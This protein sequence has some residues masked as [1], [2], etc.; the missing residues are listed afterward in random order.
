MDDVRS[1]LLTKDAERFDFLPEPE[2][3]ANTEAAPSALPDFDLDDEED[4][5][6]DEDAPPPGAAGGPGDGG[7]THLPDFDDDDDDD[8]DDEEAPSGEV[9]ALRAQLAAFDDD[10]DDDDDGGGD[11][12]AMGAARGYLRGGFSGMVAFDDD[13]DDGLPDDDDDV[14][15]PP[16]EMPAAGA[17]VEAWAELAEA[18]QHE[19]NALQCGD[20]NRYDEGPTSPGVAGVGADGPVPPTFKLALGGLTQIVGELYRAAPSGNPFA[21]DAAAAEAAAADP[22]AAFAA[23]DAPADEPVTSW[24]PAD[25]PPRIGAIRF[26]AVQ[27]LT[28][29]AALRVAGVDR[30]LHAN[31]VVGLVGSLLIDHPLSSALHDS[32][33]TLLS[34]AL[35]CPLKEVR[36]SVFKATVF[37]RERYGGESPPLC[38]RIA[39]AIKAKAALPPAR[40]PSHYGTLLATAR[41]M[42]DAYG[43]DEELAQFADSCDVWTSMCL[44]TLPPLLKAASGELC[45]PLPRQMGM[46]S[47]QDVSSYAAGGGGAPAGGGGSDA[48]TSLFSAAMGSP[49]GGGEGFDDDDDDD[50][51][52][53]GDGEDS[54]PSSPE[55]GVDAEQQAKEMAQRAFFGQRA[56]EEIA[57]MH[58][59]MQAAAVAAGMNE[60]AAA[61]AVRAYSEQAAGLAAGAGGRERRATPWAFPQLT[62]AQAEGGEFT[63]AEVEA[64]AAVAPAADLVGG[65]PA[66]EAADA[67]V[68]AATRSLAALE[69]LAAKYPA[70][71]PA[72]AATDGDAEAAA[73]AAAALSNLTESQK[74]LG[75]NS[76]PWGEFAADGDGEP[77]APAAAP[78]AAD[79]HPVERMRREDAEKQA[80]DAAAAEAAEAAAAA[81]VAEVAEAEAAEV[82]AEAAV[83]AAAA[84]AELRAAVAG[85][86]RRADRGSAAGATGGARAGA[87]RRL[88]RGAGGRRAGPGVTGCTFSVTWL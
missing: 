43:K 15:K 71:A 58:S 55:G 13:D 29:M 32:A 7:W 10:D 23:P 49:F 38:D 30:M 88:R 81:A 8:S 36:H 26:R 51:D 37:S 31:G 33:R 77:A 40:R 69:A 54:P 56:A 6:S 80:A 70:G 1:T 62:A 45:G 52:D 3:T 5:S 84:A 66:E 25:R 28:E 47:V 78:A 19:R 64:A 61:E 57:Q 2:P 59:M 20:S 73:A 72:A 39:A 11:G 75:W 60:E 14:R 76:T 63:D 41:A 17:G 85:G 44:Q 24:I 86:G 68:E 27:C 9:P 42:I 18:L 83:E 82:V 34:L 16:T 65:G 67:A 4:G 53:E 21:A 74:K 22:E 12:G 35:S 79:L 87:R 48:L 46:F 50:D